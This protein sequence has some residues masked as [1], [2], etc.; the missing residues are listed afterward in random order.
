MFRG[1]NKGFF[2]GVLIG[3]GIS[4]AGFYLYKKNQ[5]KV[6]DY[7]RKSG[8]NIPASNENNFNDFSMEEL[9]ETKE[10]LEDL[11]AEKEMTKED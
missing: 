3:A 2:K 1:V 9:V 5:K 10:H 7:L 4:A 6:D 11:I 8:I